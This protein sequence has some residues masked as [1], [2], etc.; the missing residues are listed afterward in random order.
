MLSYLVWLTRTF[1]FTCNA[2]FL[3]VLKNKWPYRNGCKVKIWFSWNVCNLYMNLY[4]KCCLVIRTTKF[5]SFCS[6]YTVI[7][8]CQQETYIIFLPA[9]GLDPP[10]AFGFGSLNLALIFTSGHAVARFVWGT[11]FPIGSLGFFITL[12]LSVALWPWGRSVFNR[13][14]Y[15]GYLR[16]GGGKGG[17][18]VELTTFV[19]RLSGNSGSLNLLEPR[20]SIQSWNGI[21]VAWHLF[22]GLPNSRG[23]L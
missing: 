2:S 13:N 14:E 17:R 8:I 12:V 7:K 23:I 20:W 10:S 18:C 9:Q 15:Q 6:L 3:T 1:S 22:Q 19:C 16:G 4:M 5:V 11:W 21:A